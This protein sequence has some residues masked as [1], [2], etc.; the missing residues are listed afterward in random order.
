MLSNDL[1]VASDGAVV[2]GRGR[3]I[4]IQGRHRK[5][6]IAFILKSRSS[7]FEQHLVSGAKRPN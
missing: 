4:Q 7:D 1:K 5:T 2:R 6:T 3:E